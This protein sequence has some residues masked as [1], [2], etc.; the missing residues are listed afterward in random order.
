[1]HDLSQ[2]ESARGCVALV[3][4]EGG[5]RELTEGSGMPSHTLRVRSSC[6]GLQIHHGIVELLDLPCPVQ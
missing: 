5:F 4:G 1:M 3:K 2:F 6:C